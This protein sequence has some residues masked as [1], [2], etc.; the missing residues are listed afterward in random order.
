MTQL[1]SSVPPQGFFSPSSAQTSS[2]C[3]PRRGGWRRMLLGE[4]VNFTGGFIDVA[5]DGA[6]TGERNKIDLRVRDQMRAGVGPGA[7]EKVQRTSGHA[8]FH[9]DFHQ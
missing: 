9:H 3:S 2:V 6:R 4:P 8:G 1:T 5:A 7:G